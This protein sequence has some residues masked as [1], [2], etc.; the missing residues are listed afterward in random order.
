MGQLVVLDS[1]AT[2]ESATDRAAQYQQEFED[3]GIFDFTFNVT[4]STYY[5]L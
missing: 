5:D 2:Y 4:A 1:F 3:R